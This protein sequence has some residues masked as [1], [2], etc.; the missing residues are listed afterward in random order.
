MPLI[1]S[2]WDIQRQDIMVFY[3]DILH[4]LWLAE[5]GTEPQAYVSF[6]RVAVGVPA[7]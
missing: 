3:H 7:R 4:N 6:R 5:G 2:T 1:V